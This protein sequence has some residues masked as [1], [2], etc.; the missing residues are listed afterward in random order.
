MRQVV[1]TR[2]AYTVVCR[3]AATIHSPP[4]VMTD[5]PE[6]SLNIKGSSTNNIFIFIRQMAVLLQRDD[7]FKLI[8]NNIKAP[9]NWRKF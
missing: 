6:E 5:N 3:V 4:C 2:A 9:R 1:T 8:N 7:H